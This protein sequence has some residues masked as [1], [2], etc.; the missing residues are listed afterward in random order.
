MQSYSQNNE[1]ELILD[2]F[3]ALPKKQYCVLEIGANDGITLSNT[4][5]ILQNGWRGALIEPSPVAFEKLRWLYQ[6]KS[7]VHLYNYAI[8]DYTGKAILYESG[9]LLTE[10]DRALV[11]T[12]V[13]EET[14]RWIENANVKF[15]P[16][17][18]QCKTFRT[19]S[20]ECPIKKFEL[21]SID[22]EGVD[23]NVLTQI[24]LTKIDCLMLIVEFNGKDKEIY[25]DYCG[26]HNL[27]LHSENAEN[28]IFVR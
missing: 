16:K 6:N 1:Q 10:K 26:E 28:L 27:S 22:V 20:R 21:I 4:F 25:I 2:Y 8:A 13:K 18:V 11:S 15:I 17:K 19:F 9:S 24:N 23:F 5:Q 7:N 12:L 3:G 14:K